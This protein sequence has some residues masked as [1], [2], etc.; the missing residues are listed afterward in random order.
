MT[1]S[2]IVT[3]AGAL[4]YGLSGSSKLQEMGRIL[5]FVGAF[6]LVHEMGSGRLHF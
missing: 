4:M 6:W 1:I 2:A 5:F 3:V